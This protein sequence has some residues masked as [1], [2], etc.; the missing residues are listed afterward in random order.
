[1]IRK[2]PSL[3]L[4]LMQHLTTQEAF[5]FSTEKW[6]HAAD[7]WNACFRQV[8]FSQRDNTPVNQRISAATRMR[9]EMGIAVEN[10]LR[11]K[12]TEMK[13]LEEV[14]SAV[15]NEALRIVGSPDGRLK[16]GQLLEIKA[17]DPA[18]FHLTKNRPL[19]AH[20]FQLKTYLWLD[21]SQTGILQSATWGGAHK[22]PFRDHTVNYDLRVGELIK[23]EVG[24]LRECQEKEDAELPDRVCETIQDGRAI[25]CPFRKECF[26]R[27]GAL[28][29]TI[30]MQWKQGR[31]DGNRTL[32]T[33]GHRN[34][35]GGA[36]VVNRPGEQSLA[37]P[38]SD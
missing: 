37:N 22:I 32:E 3:S 9:F 29:Q 13:I 31:K 5:R 2:S 26:A 24:R 33:R 30:G 8:Y 19:D 27:G 17:M 16:N 10:H 1:M 34:G 18:L 4:L 14:K 28:T 7:L 12:L 20:E 21:Q 35:D 15:R 25:L 11:G 38:A 23:R 6:L 36:Q